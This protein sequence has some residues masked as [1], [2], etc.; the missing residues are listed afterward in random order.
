MAAMTVL[1][2]DDPFARE[3]LIAAR[4]IRGWTQVYGPWTD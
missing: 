1:L 4:V 2:D 3:G